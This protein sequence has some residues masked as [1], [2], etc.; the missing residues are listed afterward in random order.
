M[1]QAD[2]L[3]HLFLNRDGHWPGFKRQGLIRRADGALELMPRPQLTGTVPDSISRAGV[4]SGPC[5]IAVSGDGTVYYSDPVAH[6][7]SQIAG[8]DGNVC[9]VPCLGGDHGRHGRVDTPRGLLLLENQR[10]LFVAD[11]GN[12]RIQIFDP[13]TGQ[14]LA[15]LGQRSVDGT[16]P[17]SAPGRLNTPWALTADAASNIYVLDYGNARIQKWNAAG[18]LIASFW[19]NV[20]ASQTLTRPI[21]V[22][23]AQVD[24]ATWV[25]I[26]EGSSPS[27]VFVFD[28]D[29][30]AVKG[31]DGKAL[32]IGAG[33][34]QSPLGVAA[35]GTALYVGDNE[36][37]R[38]FEFSF[39]EYPAWVSTARGF[40]GPVAALAL[41]KGGNLW[42]HA[43]TSD[44]P[45][46]LAA[47]T[48]YGE[49]GYLWSDSPICIDRKVA[50]QRLQAELAPLADN[51]HLDLLVYTSNDPADVPA[52][53]AASDDPFSDKKWRQ[54]AHLLGS[55]LDDLY[56][57]GQPAMCLWVAA[58]FSGDGAATP[59]LSQI[60]LQFD[61]DSYLADLPAI[62]RN[63]A[64]CGD[65]LL[66]LLSLFESIYDDVEDEIGELPA[67][68]DA[69]ATPDAFLRWLA[70]W[71]GLELDDNWSTATQRQVLGKVFELYAQRGTPA[72]LRAMLKLFAGVDAV[73][74]EPILE[75][76][77]W[78]LPAAAETCCDVCAADAA[79]AG[80][81]TW[82]PTQTSL[83]GFTTML[84]PAQP[85]GAVVGATAVLDQSHL[86]TVDEFGAPLFSDVAYQF[87]V[88]VY[89]GQVM[90]EDVLP[91]VRAL[92]EQEKPA[93]TTY[94][95]CV[96]DPGMRVG[97]ASRLGID[98]VIGGPSRSL[99][100]GDARALGEDTVLAGAPAARVGHSRLGRS[101]RLS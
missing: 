28:A 33:T 91:R 82:Q 37:R 7:I 69:Q 80:T 46:Q 31:P 78:A 68:F 25:F 65:F 100:L 88:L 15:I 53:S 92:I 39:G 21:G 59:V 42:V 97:Y 1:M 51:A 11:S 81:P 48:A 87:S 94:Q 29:G 13:D 58:Q 20:L 22:C 57:G 101:T 35:S 86:I 14:L 71:L 47:G 67:L 23:A 50:W 4:P 18:D 76:A 54:C 40:D 62:Y 74:E 83:L 12:H 56:I 45:L 96:V 9:P 52:V 8:C 17:G 72:G 43:G 89:R 2:T 24:S 98:S 32:G 3:T 61:R 30:H 19:D 75:A 38:I 26:L 44:P 60:Q 5:G 73:I 90:C 10:G 64:Q 36:A 99:S 85:Q 95:L 93:H 41:D 49:K 6:R 70:E 16:D 55:D 84:A 79:S 27:Q 66:R 34:L 77:W 63:D